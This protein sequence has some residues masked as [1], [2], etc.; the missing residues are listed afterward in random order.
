MI[1]TIRLLTCLGVL[2]VV[3]TANIHAQNSD[4]FNDA[5][6]A[7]IAVV[8]NNI[9]IEYAKIAK[10]KSSNEEILGFANTMISDHK[11][12]IKQASE[13]VSKLGVTPQSNSLS[14][15]LNEDAAKTREMLHKKSGGAFN[16]AY[17]ENEISYHKAVIDAIRNVLIP[18]TE[19]DQLKELLEGVL[20][21]LET[22]LKHAESVK[23]KIM[24]KTKK[25]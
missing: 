12:V 5:E 2:L 18:D 7:K 16:E 3:F 11:A 14:K 19:N 22:H 21:A 17:I 8:A 6:I 24:G 23:K 9:D 20:P 10:E 1:K 15:K 4:Q 25:G 13:L